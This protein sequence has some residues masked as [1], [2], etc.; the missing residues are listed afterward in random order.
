MMRGLLAEFGGA[1][2]RARDEVRS[3]EQIICRP[4]FSLILPPPW[5]R[6]RVIVIGDA[7]HTATPHLASGASIGIEDAVVLARLLQSDAPVAEI[8]EDFTARRYE[9]CRM[10]VD[11]S[12]LLGEWEK[13][14]SAPNADTVGVVARSYKALAQPV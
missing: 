5:H 11:N 2:G 14:P 10:I 12:E 3:P 6:G 8:L 13:N 4:I 9:R 7:A 1:L